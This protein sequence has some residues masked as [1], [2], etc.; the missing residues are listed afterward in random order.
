[1]KIGRWYRRGTAYRMPL[2]LT[3]HPTSGSPRV[4]YRMVN[5]VSGCS[6]KAWIGWAR[7]AELMP[8][9]FAPPEKPTARLGV[10]R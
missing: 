10:Y 7:K 1:M 8:E 9:D 4:K 6:A 3:N 2:E 5:A